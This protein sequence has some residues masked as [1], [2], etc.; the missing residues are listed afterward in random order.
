MGVV[1]WILKGREIFTNSIEILLVP[2]KKSC[3]YVSLSMKNMYL[4]LTFDPFRSRN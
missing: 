1:C 2:F 4:E 3:L